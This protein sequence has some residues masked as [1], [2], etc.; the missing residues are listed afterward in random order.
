MESTTDTEMKFW[1]LDTDTACRSLSTDPK[2]LSDREAAAR[3]RQYGPN[4]IRNHPKTS[5]LLLFLAQ[6]KSPVTLLLIAAALLSA[7]L[8]DVADTVII[9]AIVL[10]SGF[11][12]FWQE[13]GAADAVKELL[14]L[15]QLHCDV[16]RDG[17]FK[18]IPV[19]EVV[20]GDIVSLTAGDFIPG[21]SLLMESQ[22]LFADEAAFTGETFSVEKRCG[23]VA[24]DAPMAKRSNALFM[25]SHVISGRARVLVI[26][27][28]ART[29]FGKISA[30]LMSRIPETDF[31]KGIRK[32]GYMLME[33][34]L[35]LVI[36][37]FAAN[38]LL[39]KPVLD[40]FLF[41]LAL[42]V[43][44]TP[45]LLPAII[46]VNLAAGARRMA[47]Q[48]VIV[49]RLSSIENF[50][51]MNI[52]CTD[53]TGTITEG[54]VTLGGSLDGHG[55][56]SDKVLQ[57]AWLNAVMQQG[58][59]NPID[60]AICA[61]HAGTANDYHLL[62]EIP[63]DFIRKRL[64]VQV[65]NDTCTM[66]VTKGSLLGILAL[67]NQ[68]ETSGGKCVDIRDMETVL[69]EQYT[70]LS[71]AGFRTLGVAYKPVDSTR[72]ITK[73][74]ECDMIFLGFIT[75]FDPP[76]TGI[77]DTIKKLNGLGVRLKMITG[78]N[79]LVAKSLALR[80]GIGQ[81]RL[82][83]GPA[84]QKMSNAALAHQAPLTDIFAEVEPNQKERIIM[85]LKKAGHVVGFMGDGINDA[86]ALHTA[87]VGISV[88]TAVDVAKEAADIVL[89]S[90]DLNV[91]LEGILEG[92]K[93]FANTMKYIFMA[94]S[95][96]FGN[97]FS[98]AGVSLF[99][100]FLPLLPKQ[101]LLTN[102]LTDFPEM[103]IATDRVDDINIRTPQRWDMRFIRRFM[104]IF[105]LLSSVYDYLTFG[106]LLMVI[107]ANEKIFQTGWF[108]ESVIS[109]ILIVLIVR[110]RL[111]FFKS[112]PGKYL[113]TATIMILLIVLALP[114]TPFAAWF[115]FVRLS[116]SFY[117]WMLL[118]IICYMFSAELAKYWFYRGTQRLLKKRR[119]NLF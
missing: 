42:A 66:A 87:D 47:G 35:L 72:I 61:A 100:P 89:L 104:V 48:Q 23:A 86:P 99:L 21:D 22:E 94:T 112:L 6:F 49:K 4:T 79:A 31:E 69:N 52:L 103:A 45:Q 102:L 106:V 116:L 88:N 70:K 43:G 32:F 39:H 64:T 71:E 63:Y 95:A 92:R 98:M 2:G 34:T 40:S 113:F 30:E 17:Q 105:G 107:H 28:G 74:D 51:S 33:I 8:G 29:E 111:P 96:N 83:T 38:V 59:H 10:I 24:A 53:K 37:I 75:L 110:T 1:Q 101:V 76:K 65:K 14:K 20:P 36:V 56:H 15:V 54:K 25:G 67:C 84:I 13:K 81:P 117:G 41:S 57:Y 118:I 68:V 46:S 50:G 73:E 82:L 60:E 3:I 5:V 11:L 16:L 108:T 114:L 119:L 27:T 44:L 109:A 55:G 90:K 9:L 18:A 77:Y 19:E 93:T 7:S 97:M 85:V 58:F 78:D 62:A 12:G 80:I 115:G 26:Q 91:L